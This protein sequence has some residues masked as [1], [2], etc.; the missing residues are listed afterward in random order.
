[1]TTWESGG[2]KRGNPVKK[3][4]GEGGNPKKKKKKRPTSGNLWRE[5]V[6][7][8]LEKKRKRR[9]LIIAT[10]NGPRGYQT[11]KKRVKEKRE[12]VKF[13]WQTKTLRFPSRP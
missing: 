10:K 13:T 8:K 1:L 12:G 9:A 6:R 4:G 2:R 5:K 7:E 3:K 11:R